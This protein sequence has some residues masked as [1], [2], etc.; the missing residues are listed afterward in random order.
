MD[1][2]YIIYNNH[3][4]TLIWHLAFSIFAAHA[5][6]DFLIWAAHALRDC[7]IWRLAFGVEGEVGVVSKKMSKKMLAKVGEVAENS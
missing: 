6:C 1:R 5:L 2:N 3:P 7:F 4:F